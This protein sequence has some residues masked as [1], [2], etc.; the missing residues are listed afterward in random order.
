MEMSTPS[1]Q[2][3]L[4]LEKYRIYQIIMI[5]I[6]ISLESSRNKVYPSL[7]FLRWSGQSIPNLEMTF[8]ICGHECKVVLIF[9]F[10]IFE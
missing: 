1:N 9:Y 10:Y 6:L 3:D 8:G 4:D 5:L 2:V 7:K